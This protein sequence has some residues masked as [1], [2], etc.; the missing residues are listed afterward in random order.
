MSSANWLT[1]NRDLSGD[2]YSPLK[3]ISTT[4]SAHLQLR[5]IAVPTGN[6]SRDAAAATAAATLLVFSLP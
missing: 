5:Y 6:S 4:N 1:F 3:Q 2:R